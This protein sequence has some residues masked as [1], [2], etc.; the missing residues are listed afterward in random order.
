MQVDVTLS[1]GGDFF[2]AEVDGKHAGQLEFIRHNGV[3][4]YTHTEVDDEFEGKGVGS[5]LARAALDAARAEGVKVVP[6][7]PFV[8]AWIERH[9]DY[10]DL[11]K[12]R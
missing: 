3:I 9:P 2:E 11:V 4:V 6:R 10:A 7:C 12:G 5:A 1:P 8:K